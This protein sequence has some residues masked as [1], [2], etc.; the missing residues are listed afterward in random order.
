MATFFYCKKKVTLDIK[1]TLN[2]TTMFAYPL[3]FQF[4][5]STL[6]NDFTVS[7]SN[8]KTL[9]YVRQKMLKLKE[10]VIVYSDE[11]K[12]KEL[13]HINANKWLDFNTAYSFSTSM[14]DA[15]LGKV[16][17]K[18]WASI[19]KARY[20]I[21]DENNLHALTI[22][23]ENPWVKLWDGL[24]KEVPLVNIFSGYFFNPKYLVVKN[25]GTVV[26]KLS[27]EKSFWGRKFKLENISTF[28]E[29]EEIRI[30]LSLMMMMLLERRRG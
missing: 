29:K 14:K 11:T 23:E 22:Q 2:P 8:G 19:W 12:T 5:I 26:A 25:D 15:E 9:A 4:K 24:L 17:R 21:I 28:E 30:L 16:A 6:A 13:F 10:E 20:E 7:D 27:K 18:G 1:F 3:N